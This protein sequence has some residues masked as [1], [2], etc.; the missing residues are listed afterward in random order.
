M[1]ATLTVV[2]GRLVAG[3][4]V[5]VKHQV[6]AFVAH[7][8]ADALPISFVLGD[9]EGARLKG[10]NHSSSVDE[11]A[12]IVDASGILRGGQGDVRRVC[13]AAVFGSVSARDEDSVVAVIETCAV[14]VTAS[15]GE[16]LCEAVINGAQHLRAGACPSQHMHPARRLARHRKGIFGDS[17][18]ACDESAVS[19]TTHTAGASRSS[20]EKQVAGNKGSEQDESYL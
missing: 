5:V 4:V 15:D 9:D 12:L 10:E 1:T 14:A 2:S 7:D 19:I 17:F 18:G 8:I 11:A 20:V 6:L 13:A 3:A 16:E